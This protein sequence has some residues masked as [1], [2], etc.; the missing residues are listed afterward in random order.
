M[1]SQDKYYVYVHRYASGEKEGD[2][3]YVGKGACRKRFKSKQG[4]S[5]YWNRIVSKYGFKY[6][7]LK[8]FNS[9]QC[10]FSYE[11]ILIS[12][13]GRKNLCNLTDGGEGASGR[14]VSENTRKKVSLT[15]KGTAPSESTMIEAIKKNS[16]PVGTRCGLRF[17]SIT[18]AAKFAHPDNPK[19]GKTSISGCVRGTHK[20]AYGYEWG[21]ILDEEVSYAYRERKST[22]SPWKHIAVGTECG[23][24]FESI[25]SAVLWLREKGKVKA[26]TGSICRCCKGKGKSAYGYKW[27][28]L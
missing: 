3:F 24:V 4:R 11:K 25:A 19:A 17:S 12:I 16:K 23:L 20:F 21:F 6:E 2:V 5:I 10:A 22:Y 28:Y 8:R 15:N 18:E 9:E 13:I 26:G 7:I 14:V 27:K 1:S